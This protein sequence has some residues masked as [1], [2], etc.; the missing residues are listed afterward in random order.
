ML[1]FA[2]LSHP[3]NWVIV[4]LMIAIAVMAFTLF[5]PEY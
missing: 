5:A 4:F 1:N 3:L 2:L